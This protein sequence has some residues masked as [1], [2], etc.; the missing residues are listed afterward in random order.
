MKKTWI[1]LSLIIVVFLSFGCKSSKSTPSEV[2]EDANVV[3]EDNSE[4]ASQEVNKE[5]KGTYM[6]KTQEEAYELLNKNEAI[7]IDV[8]TVEEYNEGHIVG[9]NLVPLDT[10]ETEIIKA[11]PDK[12]AVYLVYCRSGNRSQQATNIMVD[13]GY[14]EVYDIGGINTWPYETEQ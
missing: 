1:L 2:Y 11:Y 7:L 12:E 4:S 3:S 6:T 13:L 8:R 10:I 14:L 5:M 9:A